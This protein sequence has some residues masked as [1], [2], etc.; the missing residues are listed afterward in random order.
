MNANPETSVRT[1]L[2]YG[3]L[4]S[5]TGGDYGCTRHNAVYVRHD[6]ARIDSGAEAE[7]IGIHEQ[8]FRIGHRFGERR[9]IVTK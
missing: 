7:V 9:S 5:C 1:G 8:L 2:L 3:L 6:Y 4:K